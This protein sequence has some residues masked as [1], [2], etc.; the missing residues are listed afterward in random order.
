MLVEVLISKGKF[1]SGMIGKIIE[2][3]IDIY[4][5]KPIY[6]IEFFNKKNK[7]L[8][9]DFYSYYEIKKI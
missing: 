5:K 3:N 9:F 1:S 7:S 2:E 8:G 6:K 4:T